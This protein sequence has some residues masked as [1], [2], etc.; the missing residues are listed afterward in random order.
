VWH[1][2]LTL[3][4]VALALTTLNGGTAPAEAAGAAP[5]ARTESGV[6]RGI[7]SG[8]ADSF[9][10]IP[11]ARPPVGQLRWRPPRSGARWTGV[12]DA[13]TYGNRCAALPSPNG[14]RSDT[15]DCLFLNVQRPAGARPGQ[16][17]PVFFWI[18]GGSLQN[19]SSN[20]YDGSL[21]VN[22]TG[23]VV[24]TVNYRLGVFGFLAHPALTREAG[25]SGNYGLQ[26]QQAALRWVQRNIDAFGGDPRRVTV[27]GESAGALSVCAHLSAPGSRDLFSA[28]VIESGTCVSQTLAQVE[29]VGTALA[30]A[31]GC[32]DAATATQCLRAVPEA[33][34]VDAT[35][36]APIL[37]VRNVPTLPDDPDTA[38][39]TGR[40]ARVP[41]LIGA[42][43]DEGRFFSQ[44][45]IGQT[46]DQYL[47]FV[48]ATFGSGADAVLARYP[49][50]AS[51]DAFTVAYLLGAIFTDSG[52]F[53]GIGGC[54]NRGLT[55]AIAGY[56]PTYTYQFD[57]RTGP[58][59]APNPVGY[60]WG[61]AHA[62]GLAYLWPSF[63]NGAP[64]A[65]T[66][67]AAER[68]LVTDMVRAFGNFV[69]NGRPEAAG[70]TPWPAFNHTEKT[71]SLRTGG[72]SALISDARLA[73]EHN[74]DLWPQS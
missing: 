40:F 19:G 42:N 14:P 63:N 1:K 25:E 13:R 7:G 5:I 58:G 56:T 33:R 4:T 61:A 32:P 47:A 67:T 12:R 51:S 46:R 28:A 48:A 59:P 39:H 18:H 55:Q 44:G 60:V 31:V 9:L 62:A 71:M 21:I 38:L 17:L 37:V 2:L 41:V 23:V 50:P 72:D 57:H 66:F 36:S 26:D 29:K 27:G 30:Q 52:F 64:I 6:V 53:F 54:A 43:R 69:R 65:P 10:G 11:Y 49:W 45:F 22:R 35:P 70:S 73:T 15:E 16:R 34:L 74:C 24:V 8:G 68:R 3:F 20:Q